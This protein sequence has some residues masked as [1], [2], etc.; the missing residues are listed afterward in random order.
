MTTT[1]QT[2][3]AAPARTF[4]RD[5]IVRLGQSE[6]TW[7][8]LAIAVQALRQVPGDIGIRLLAAS[9]FAKLGLRTAAADHLALVPEEVIRAPEIEGLIRVLHAMASDV[10]PAEARTATCRANLEAL[11]DRGPGTGT[12]FSA[13]AASAARMLVC[14][15]SDGNIIQRPADGG[16]AD[17]LNVSDQRSAAAS[18]AREHFAP[19]SPEWDKPI[20]LEG[21]DPPWMLE[22]LARARTRQQT[23]HLPPITILQADP[24]QFFDGLASVDLTGVLSAGNITAL[25]GPDASRRLAESLASRARYHITGPSLTAL[26]TRSRLSPPLSQVLPAAMRSQE[27][28][29][30]ALQRR[31]GAIYGE[32]T[33][34]WWKARFASSSTEPLRI[35]IPT[36]RYSTFVQHAS[37]DLVRALATLGHDAR[38]MIEPDDFTKFAA[39]AYLAEIV[40]FQPD[41]IV[42]I[43]YPRALLGEA[44]PRNIPFVCWLQDAMPHLFDAKVGRSQGPLDFVVGHL[45]DELFDTHGYPRSRALAAPI[46]AD[47]T[48]FHTAPVANRPRFEC[49]IAYVSHQSEPPR[50]QHERLR[51]EFASSPRLAAAIDRLQPLMEREAFKPLSELATIDARAVAAA[52]LRQELGDDAEPRIIDVVARSYCQPHIDRLIRHQTLEWAADI[53]DKRGWRLRLYGKGW[54]NHP[55]LSQYAAGPLDHGDDLRCSYNAAA[56]HL[57]TMA[58]ALVHQR[59]IE[60]ILSGGFPLCRLHA[61]ERWSIVECLTRLGVR[62]GAQPLDISDPNIPNR[63]RVTCWSDAPA[64]MQLAS[65]LQRLGIFEDTIRPA[66]GSRLGPMID[67]QEWHRGASLA[68]HDPDLWSAFGLLGQSEQFMFH[69]AQT[70]EQRIE[71]ILD[72]PDLREALSAGARRRFLQRFTYSGF[73]RRLLDF[74][75]DR[76]PS[77]VPAVG[78]SA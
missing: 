26:L 55:R 3:R 57:H 13:W 43:N 15:A 67:E 6:K 70:L 16:A 36:T 4:T 61:P 24:G 46:V 63:R 65:I 60:C 1:A 9:A 50:A 53:A 18:L 64:L 10:V 62:Q 8:F 28:L 5:D 42:L 47:E 71:L 51:A 74:V 31:A 34:R 17:W 14:R 59:L 25:I 72:R 49:E 32:R 77:Q 48:K 23:G 21:A 33:P 39:T 56:V 69:S 66:A 7:E 27:D 52:A 29:M 37:R 11:A 20:Y 76:L 58:H 30:L 41:L 2:P 54:E 38:L 78:A 75:R 22:Q 40:D 44:I 19:S 73:A 68:D 12:E 35:L 45:W